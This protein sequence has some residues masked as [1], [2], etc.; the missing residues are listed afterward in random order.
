MEIG[1]MKSSFHWLH[2]QLTSWLSSYADSALIETDWAI[3]CERKQSIGV[4]WS[5]WEQQGLPE[6]NA[7]GH[8]KVQAMYWKKWRTG[9][10]KWGQS[11]RN[12]DRLITF[13][14]VYATPFIWS[15]KSEKNNH[16][17]SI[18]IVSPS[19]FGWNPPFFER[20]RRRLKV[21]AGSLRQW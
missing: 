3:G 1:I 18:S 8:Q 7:S 19:S 10:K 4:L 2:H 5:Y 21:R 16:P 20:F 11:D 13:L 14:W 15:Q 12:W 17:I 6:S 9:F